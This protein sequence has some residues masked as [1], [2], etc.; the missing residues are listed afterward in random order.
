MA[1]I[2][3]DKPVTIR[4]D[5]DNPMRCGQDCI[6]LSC[7]DCFAECLVFSTCGEG[8]ELEEDNFGELRTKSCLEFFGK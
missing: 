2:T 1:K 5:D 8:E 6:F 7:K 4:V 3:K